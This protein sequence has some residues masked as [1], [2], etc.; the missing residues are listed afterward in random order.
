M[1]KE[2]VVSLTKEER[3]QLLILLKKGKISAHKLCRVQIVLHADAGASDPT[4]ATAVHTDV[5][6]V[7]R[8]R[9]CFVEEGVSARIVLTPLLRR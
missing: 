3:E 2:Y 1:A 4:I 8:I 9:K 5:T 7:E 6:T